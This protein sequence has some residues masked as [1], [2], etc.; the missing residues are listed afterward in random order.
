M[1][2]Y[3]AVDPF[4][5]RR[6]R[7][8]GRRA[9]PTPDPND[10]PEPEALEPGELARRVA[11][12]MGARAAGQPEPELE[13]TTLGSVEVVR[14]DTGAPIGALPVTIGQAL[15]A[16]ETEESPGDELGEQD[17]SDPLE[18]VTGDPEPTGEPS[19]DWLSAVEVAAALGIDPAEVRRRCREGLLA[20]RKDEQGSW[21][22]DPAEVPRS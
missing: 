9:L 2:R 18:G 20:A 6:A 19:A 8:P 16:L 21:R 22:I 10:E 5:T 15:D 11:A 1:S 7:R 17:P 3:R 4:A 12:A 13:A 14:E